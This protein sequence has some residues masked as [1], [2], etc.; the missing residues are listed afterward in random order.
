MSADSTETRMNDSEDLGRRPE[1][2]EWTWLREWFERGPAGGG[3]RA[4]GWMVAI[5]VFGVLA[6]GKLAAVERQVM[7]GHVPRALAALQPIGALPETNRLKLAIG[8]P[9][10]N[11]AALSNLLVQIYDPAHPQY[12]RFLQ[13]GEFAE[14]FGPTRAQYEAV[15]AFARSYGLRVT[16]RHGNRVVLDVEGSVG[17][18]QRAFQV[19]LLKY[20]HPTE[21]RSVFAPD[22]EPTVEAGVPVLDICGLTDLARPRPKSLHKRPI[23]SAGPVPKGGS[24][25]NGNYLGNDYRA[26]YLPG[27]TLTGTGQVLGLLEFDGYYPNDITTYVNLAGLASVPLENVLLDGSSGMPTPPPNSGNSEV[28]LDIEMAICMAPGL[29][30]ILVYEAP[31][32]GYANDLISRMAQDNRA[33]Q[34]SCSWD[35]GTDANATTEQIFL[36]F[37]AQGQTFFNASGDSG[38]YVHAVPSPD[39]DPNITLVGGTTL[40]TTGAGGAWVSETVWNAGSGIASGGGIST[41]YP[42]PFWQQG[43]NMSG[44]GGSSSKR[45]LP[46]VS[47]VADNIWIV[48]DN[49]QQYAI[50]GTSAS[51]PLWAGLTALINEYAAARGYPRVGFLNPTIYSLAKTA[52]YAS[53]FHDITTGNNTNSTTGNRFIATPGFDL[54]TGW[55]S[56]FGQNLIGALAV[57]DTLGI[58]PAAGF[59]ANGPPGGPF[60][61][62]SAT[63]SLTN[64]GPTAVQWAIGN[65]ASW[66]NVSA[67]EGV[68]N[69]AQT[70]SLTI[71]LSAVASSLASSNYTAS[72]AFSNLTTGVIQS[73]M[74]SLAVGTSLV[75]NGGFESGDFAYWTLAGNAADSFNFVDNGYSVLPYDGDYAAAMGQPGS[76]ATLT[77]PVATRPGQAYQLSFW[78]TSVPD[79]DNLTTPN[80][81]RVSVDSKVVFQAINVGILDWTNRHL[82][83]TALGTNM[84]LVFGASDDPAFIGLDDIS[85]L[86]V[87]APAFQSVTLTNSTIRLTWSTQPGLPYQ[88]QYATGFPA[89]TWSNLGTAQTAVGTSLGATDPNPSAPA[90]FYRVLLA[91]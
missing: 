65:P 35:F 7:R 2:F 18:I 84:N 70:A 43:I 64:S 51:A 4:P 33:A 62:V 68:L 75:L 15:A 40:A 48:A 55:G 89:T 36:Q 50:Y 42:L 22:R 38:A 31:Q 76:L 27:V 9:L 53:C 60:N 67:S 91:P 6:T 71:G 16:R 37:A 30:R 57:P 79:L 82:V 8:L 25:P 81:V 90:R 5:V 10:R 14:R 69:P 23:G 32:D 54:C 80:Q 61:T 28:A 66:L 19:A 11:T 86:P 88:L 1:G 47:L 59:G 17:E 49:G 73:R 63:F 20:P 41:V 34:L 21:A 58:V 39:D 12:R 29:S 85:L 26:A 24:G 72:V 56:P 3:A 74:F 77:Q 45:N 52:A 13:P 87:P 83:V 44:N 78:Y 46:D